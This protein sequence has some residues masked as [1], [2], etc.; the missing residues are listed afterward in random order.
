MARSN[1]GQRD[2]YDTV[3]APLE[4]SLN[5]ST[6]TTLLPANPDRFGY[7]VGNLAQQLIYVKEKATGDPDSDDR[8]I[9]VFGRTVYESPEKH[10]PIG[11]ISAK[12]A[13]GTPSVLVTEK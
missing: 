2:T 12:A 8:G 1:R 11:E 3:E 13:S 9:P 7:T 6:Y 10:V 5:S 4:I